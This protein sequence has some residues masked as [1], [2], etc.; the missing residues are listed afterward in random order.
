MATNMETQ[1]ASAITTE[2]ATT[3]EIPPVPESPPIQQPSKT[4]RRGPGVLLADGL[5]K[6]YI[7]TSQ[8]RAKK[9]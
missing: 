2:F 6:Y 4:K 8:K 3:S 7:P 9:N 5:S 1:E